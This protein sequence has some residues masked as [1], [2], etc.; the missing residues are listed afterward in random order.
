MKQLLKA[1]LIAAALVVLIKVFAFTS[2]TIPSTGM[3]NSL[4]RG[5]RVIVNKWSYGLR[6]PLMG[7]T[8]YH[9]L[10]ARG[11][12]RG[13]IV[14][15]NNPAGKGTIDRRELFIN[16]CI[17]LPGDTLMLNG[18]LIQTRDQVLSPDSKLVYAYP[19][20]QEDLVVE[21]MRRVGIGDNKLVG[22]DRG[23]FLRSFSHY[24]IY[25][26]R[27]ELRGQV[28]FRSLQTDTADG[29]HPFVVPARGRAMRVYPWNAKLLCN[30]IVQHEGRQA[31]LQGDTLWVDGRRVT[32]YTFTKDYHWVASN[33]SVSLCD[34]RLFGFVPDDHI[35]GRASLIWFS[36]DTEE[37]FWHGFR[38]KR[39]FRLVQ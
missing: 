34:S 38:W 23:D 9:R 33:N 14:L 7:M 4:L 22:F 17:G 39:F 26:M 19:G 35:I 36:K 11:V 30:T 18:Q 8:G 20:E 2:C 28:T 32:S 10:A 37:P 3:E 24:E 15:F 1:V 12:E 29:V 6:L 25:L 21:A 5:E 16:R 31:R 13:D 27:Q